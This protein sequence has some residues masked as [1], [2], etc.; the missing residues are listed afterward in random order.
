MHNQKALHHIHVLGFINPSPCACALKVARGTRT[1]HVLPRH[2]LFSPFPEF[3]SAL[4]PLL[5]SRGRWRA[6]LHPLDPHFKVAAAHLAHDCLCFAVIFLRALANLIFRG[7][8]IYLVMPLQRCFG[9]PSVIPLA[10]ARQWV[11]RVFVAEY[12]LFWHTDAKF[13]YPHLTNQKVF[14]VFTNLNGPHVQGDTKQAC[15][16]NLHGI[17]KFG[18][19]V[20][21]LDCNTNYMYMYRVAF[22]EYNP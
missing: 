7:Q 16:L 19:D 5:T 18:L 12:F 9:Y 10:P 2:S 8:P 14:P 3:G 21:P 13:D 1:A 4:F 15:L 11:A 17:C 6:A 22:I 20:P